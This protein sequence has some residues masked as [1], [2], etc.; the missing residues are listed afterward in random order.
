MAFLFAKELASTSGDTL[1]GGKGVKE[2]LLGCP[3]AP[4]AELPL[5]FLTAPPDLLHSGSTLEPTGTGGEGIGE[6]LPDLL[7][8]PPDPSNPGLGPGKGGDVCGSF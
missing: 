1:G 2:P 3:E 7:K 5:D 6:V 8:A 4:P